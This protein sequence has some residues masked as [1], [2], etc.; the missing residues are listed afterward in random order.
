MK[1]FAQHISLRWIHL[2]GRSFGSIKFAFMFLETIGQQET[3]YVVTQQKTVYNFNVSQYYI[4][5]T[6]D[7]CNIQPKSCW[8]FFFRR[9]RNWNVKLYYDASR[10]KKRKILGDVDMKEIVMLI[11]RN[12]VVKKKHIDLARSSKQKPAPRPSCDAVR[13][14]TMARLL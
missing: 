1:H 8:L 7:I 11:V 13:C 6:G 3:R 5:E 12:I 9:H 2:P 14:V 4:P 10:P